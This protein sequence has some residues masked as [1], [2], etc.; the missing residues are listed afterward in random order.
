MSV[1]G[2]YIPKNQSQVGAI[3]PSIPPSLTCWML[4]LNTLFA[5]E[6]GPTVAGRVWIKLLL[7][8]TKP[9]PALLGDL[10][11][12]SQSLPERFLRVFWAKPYQ[13][14]SLKNEGV[15]RA[16][17]RTIECKHS[18]HPTGQPTVGS[19]RLS[20]VQQIWH[21]KEWNS[22]V[23]WLSGQGLDKDKKG[24]QMKKKFTPANKQKAN[25]F[26]KHFQSYYRSLSTV[27]FQ[28]WLRR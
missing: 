20:Y 15:S 11:M 9:F 19:A 1:S 8:L 6:L 10:K 24:G 3:P 2:C 12:Y 14:T 25:N 17:W 26:V 27:N 18:S 7:V 5:K 16:G 4:C 21:V 28:W 22:Q 13:V 23:S